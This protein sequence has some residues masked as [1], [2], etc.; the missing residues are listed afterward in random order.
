MEAEFGWNTAGGDTNAQA[1]AGAGAADGNVPP[2]HNA[3]HDAQHTAQSYQ[4]A[5]GARYREKYMMARAAPSMEAEGWANASEAL[6]A[7]ARD[8]G[9]QHGT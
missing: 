6:L 3:Q 8:E 7:A 5:G 4:D 9:V 1:N 2:T